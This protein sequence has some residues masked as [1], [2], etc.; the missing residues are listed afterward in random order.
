MH[1]FGGRILEKG[2]NSVENK[3]PWYKSLTL[4]TNIVI[5]IAFILK[6]QI[7]FELSTEETAAIIT[8]INLILRVK[9]NQSIK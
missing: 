7:G 4:W 6:D 2:V 8:V 1:G 9:T 5:L 3:K